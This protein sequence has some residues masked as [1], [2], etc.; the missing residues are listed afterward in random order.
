M[1]ACMHT[2]LVECSPQ[3]RPT[4]STMQNAIALS[5][6]PFVGRESCCRSLNLIREMAP[7]PFHDDDGLCAIFIQGESGRGVP[8]AV[9][10]CMHALLSNTMVFLS[11]TATSC[12]LAPPFQSKGLF[13]KGSE[14]APQEVSTPPKNP[15]NQRESAPPIPR[16]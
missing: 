5:I 11:L 4:D 6:V 7:L 12:S 9:H 14:V 16:P 10:A 15:I 2:F 1:H 8:G 13:S 3:F